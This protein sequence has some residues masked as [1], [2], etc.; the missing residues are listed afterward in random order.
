MLLTILSNTLCTLHDHEQALVFRHHLGGALLRCLAVSQVRPVTV[1]RELHADYQE[2]SSSIRRV[3][4][5][6]CAWVR[7]QQVLKTW[8]GSP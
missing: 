7:T 4:T 8:W 2:G 1:S 6:R 3:F 5:M